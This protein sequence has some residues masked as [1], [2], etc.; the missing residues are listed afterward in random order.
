MPSRRNQAVS[1]AIARR[2]RRLAKAC[3]E[4]ADPVAEFSFFDPIDVLIEKVF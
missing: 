2:I 3:I 1:S 4:R